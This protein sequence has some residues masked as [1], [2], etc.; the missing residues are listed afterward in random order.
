MK[1]E[2]VYEPEEGTRGLSMQVVGR[3]GKD[4]GP[5]QGGH[6]GASGVPGLGSRQ[7]KLEGG[8]PM[9]RVAGI[10]GDAVWRRGTRA[11]RGSVKTQ[12]LGWPAGAGEKNESSARLRETPGR[13]S[14]ALLGRSSL[15]E[16]GQEVPV[17]QE[18]DHVPGN[19]VRFDDERMGDW[20]GDEIRHASELCALDRNRAVAVSRDDEAGHGVEAARPRNDAKFE[21]R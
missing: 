15:R 13:H 10:A 14:N 3:L 11:E 20:H 18:L 5:W 19:S 9:G 16:L 17:T 7:R 21:G 4:H 1:F 6:S 2:I 12:A 8:N